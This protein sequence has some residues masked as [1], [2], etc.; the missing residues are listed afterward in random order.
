M[1]EL[2]LQRGNQV[3]T[4]DE[5]ALLPTVEATPTY[6]P[7][8]HYGFARSLKTISQDLLNGYEMINE[9]YG[10][11]RQ[12]QQFFGVI[13]FQK[14]HSEM[15]LAIGMRNSTDKSIACGFTTGASV[16]VCDNLCFSS[17]GGI[18]VLRKHT[19]GLLATL[20]D[21][22]ITVLYRSQYTFDKL[23]EDSQ[24]LRSREMDNDQAFKMLGLLFGHGLL[25]PRQLPVAK[26]EWLK[27]AH[28]EFEP[29]NAWSLMN[30][31]TDAL[32][33]TTPLKVMEHH[34][35]VHDMFMGEVID[36]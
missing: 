35:G 8:S 23:V 25:S 7:I 6:Q 1:S 17:E 15:S 32:K 29:R 2:L 10:V 11:A 26:R 13:N 4:L 20:E 28:P 30:S 19:K 34:I 14:D 36:V 31:I 24:R 12:G 21:N 3:V 22:M 33:S 18:T 27:P 9:R 5:L 16:M